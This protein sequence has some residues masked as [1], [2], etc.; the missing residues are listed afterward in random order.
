M[1]HKNHPSS[2]LGQNLAGLNKHVI[3]SI[4]KNDM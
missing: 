1:I 2:F 4:A 3:L